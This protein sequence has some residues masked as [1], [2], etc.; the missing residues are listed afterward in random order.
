MML[1]FALFW[2]LQT[3]EFWDIGLP[4]GARVEDRKLAGDTPL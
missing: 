4:A 2:V 1:I 3:I